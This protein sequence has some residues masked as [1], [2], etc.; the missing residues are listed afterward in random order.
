MHNHLFEIPNG[1]LIEW[2]NDARNW[3]IN[4]YRREVKRKEPLIT[5]YTC[6]LM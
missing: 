4:R 3:F 6:I 2:N 5:W 1:R